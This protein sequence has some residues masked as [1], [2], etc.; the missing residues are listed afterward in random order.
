VP[1]P[2]HWSYFVRKTEIKHVFFPHPSERS[3][4]SDQREAPVLALPQNKHIKIVQFIF[5]KI[6][7]QDLCLHL[8]Q[9]LRI[10]R[11]KR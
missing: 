2:D 9:K 11:S 3:N 8:T 6:R 7:C 4:S 1:S 10:N 5:V